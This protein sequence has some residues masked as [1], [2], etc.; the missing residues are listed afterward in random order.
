MAKVLYTSFRDNIN[1]V[2][3]I[4]IAKGPI[5]QTTTYIGLKIAHK[6]IAIYGDNALNNDTFCNY[7]YA[8]FLANNYDDNPQSNLSLPRYLFQGRASYIQCLAHICKLIAE[9]VFSHFHLR[10]R[11]E[12]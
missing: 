12:A 10:T 7:F 3:T 4:E 1:E 9:S 11:E 6:I 5:K 8:K 2:E